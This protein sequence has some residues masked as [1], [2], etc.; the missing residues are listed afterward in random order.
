VVLG[1]GVVEGHEVMEI[2]VFELGVGETADDCVDLTA[3][4]DG[5]LGGG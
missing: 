2:I 3:M 4:L 1:R 5:G